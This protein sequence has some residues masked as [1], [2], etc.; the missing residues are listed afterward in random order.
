MSL[1]TFTLL[2]VLISLLGIASGI[3]VM[4]GLLTSKRLNAWTSTFLVSTIATSITGFM[5]PFH[6]ITP[7]HILGILSLLALTI[8]VVT[9]YVTHMNGASRWIYVITASISLYFN[10]FV[11]VV[12]L[13]EKVPAIH[14]LAPTQ[15]EPPFAIAQLLV[16]AL[17]V[18]LTVMAVRRF[19]PAGSSTTGI[20]QNAPRRAA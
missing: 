11:L 6:G 16:M 10:V 20:S 3:V 8:A 4:Y 19:H 7:G 2:H 9:R 14:A 13:F 1:S 15:K 18:V 17:F 5:Y 12:Q